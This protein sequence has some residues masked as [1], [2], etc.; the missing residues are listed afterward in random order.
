[1]SGSASERSAV[2]TAIARSLPDLMCSIDAGK[3]SKAN[4]T[5]PLSR[6]ISMGDDPR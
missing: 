1:M 2:V 3:L 4:C 6:S 5:R